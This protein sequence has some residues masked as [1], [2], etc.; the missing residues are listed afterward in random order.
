MRSE[1]NAQMVRT[2]VG[3]VCQFCGQ[4]L[5][6][7]NGAEPRATEAHNKLSQLDPI[8]SMI[9]VS[10]ALGVAPG[11]IDRWV[12]EGSF[13]SKVRLGPKRIGWRKSAVEAW[14]AARQGW[15]P[16]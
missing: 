4:P 15:H 1:S 7:A 9:A 3:S 13:P 6:E 14:I 2:Q 12:R 16:S 8:L 11:T 5:L 10:Q